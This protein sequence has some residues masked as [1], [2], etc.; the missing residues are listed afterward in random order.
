MKKYPLIAALVIS[1]FLAGKYLFPPKAEVKEVIKIV[2]VEKKQEK[3]ASVS[4]SVETKKPDGTVVTEVV[5][6]ENTQT[7]TAS[8]SQ[9]DSS[10]TSKGGAKLTL[11]LLAIKSADDFSAPTQFGATITVPLLG[12]I[13][14]QAL[15]TTDK[16]IG[17][18][19]ALEF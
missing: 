10:K 19:L 14:A 7:D 6:T 13:K 8:S 17:I 15:G 18:G 1:A 3:K 9:L 16:R 12:N 2:T 11:G 5:V 4:R